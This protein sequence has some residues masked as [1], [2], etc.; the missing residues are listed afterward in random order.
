MS[1][2][3][4]IVDDNEDA[5]MLLSEVLQAVGHSVKSA[6]DGP[7][8]LALAEAF[9]PDVAILD[10]GLPVMDGYELA[11]RLRETMSKPP[12]MVAL[13]GYGRPADQ[14]KSAAAGFERH[15]VKPVDLKSLL[16]TLS[17]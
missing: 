11:A 15:L 17:G 2:R 14:E 6:G 9:Q 12:R 5:R 10:I 13:S 7:E 8:A 16:Q 1:A 4:L 3:I